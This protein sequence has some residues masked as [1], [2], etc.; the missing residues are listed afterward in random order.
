MTKELKDLQKKA[1]TSPRKC[2]KCGC[3]CFDPFGGKILIHD[4]EIC[5]GIVNIHH[6]NQN[7]ND[8]KSRA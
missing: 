4:V 2:P 5:G 6:N 1:D 7:A 3:Q 8:S